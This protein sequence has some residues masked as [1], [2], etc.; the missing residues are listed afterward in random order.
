MFQE[1]D[2]VTAPSTRQGERNGMSSTIAKSP[3]LHQAALPCPK[4]IGSIGH[5][6]LYTESAK[7][8]RA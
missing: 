5:K 2:G 1:N 8:I 4:L 6:R 7:C 3:S